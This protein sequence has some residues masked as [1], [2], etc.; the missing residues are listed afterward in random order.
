MTRS[1]EEILSEYQRIKL[2]S[3]FHDQFV[4]D[5]YHPYYYWNYQTYN[6]LVHSHLEALK[7]LLL[8]NLTWHLYPTRLLPTV[9]IKYQYGIFYP[10]LFMN[11]NLILEVLMVIPSL[12]YTPWH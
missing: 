3:E 5:N 10:E 2:H 11:G 4:T 8:L 9:L 1:Q 6:S 7:M 12:N